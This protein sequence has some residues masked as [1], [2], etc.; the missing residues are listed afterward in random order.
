MG[1]NC[2]VD[3]PQDAAGWKRLSSKADTALRPEGSMAV[4]DPQAEGTHWACQGKRGKWGASH[5][6]DH[7]ELR[8]AGDPQEKKH[9]EEGRSPL[10]SR[11]EGKEASSR[12]F[13]P[14]RD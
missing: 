14:E 3:S 9:F 13:K 5:W 11:H 6:R 4:R 2:S 10:M 7:W 1:K 8:E 12:D